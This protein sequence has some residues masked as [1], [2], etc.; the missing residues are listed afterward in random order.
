M[1]SKKLLVYLFRWQVSGFVMLVPFKILLALGVT[2]TTLNMIV[3][4]FI[5]GLVFYN[6]DKTI[7]NKGGSKCKCRCVNSAGSAS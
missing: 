5:G 2:S 6:I 7:F 3:A 1:L 4:S